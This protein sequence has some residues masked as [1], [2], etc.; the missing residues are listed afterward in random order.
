[1]K[2][3]SAIATL[4]ERH[5]DEVHPRA[6]NGDFGVRIATLE[7]L[8]DSAPVIFPLQ[9]AP[10]IATRRLGPIAYRQFMYAGG[11]AEPREGEESHDFATLEKAALETDLPNLLEARQQFENVQTAIAAIRKTCADRLGASGTPNLQKLHNLVSNIFQLLNGIVAKLDPS[12]AVSAPAAAE[13]EAVPGAVA[14]TSASPIKS[15]KQA[16]AALE[17]AAAYF[18]RSEPS[19]PALLLLRQAQ[20]LTGKSLVEVLKILM[21]AKLEEAKFLIGKDQALQISI[22][23]LAQFARSS[24]EATQ[25]DAVDGFTSTL[26]DGDEAASAPIKAQSRQEV[27]AILEQIA[28]FYRNAEPSSPIAFIVER[29]R[30]VADRD[31]LALVK[32]LLAPPP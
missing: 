11:E 30:G 24:E 1:M 6:T 22:E 2:F 10:L 16:A 13:T 5:W 9:Y 32:E 15:R 26:A 4:L 21:P 18:A 23:Q 7:T 17:A 25:S 20:Q 29:A 12:A 3:T 28:A 31:F 19:N 14:A 8:D 27:F